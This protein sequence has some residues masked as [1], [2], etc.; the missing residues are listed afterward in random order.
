MLM[1][2]ALTNNQVQYI[3]NDWDVKTF[4]KSLLDVSAQT[5]DSIEVKTLLDE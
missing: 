1:N 2:V 3:I 4:Y 5:A